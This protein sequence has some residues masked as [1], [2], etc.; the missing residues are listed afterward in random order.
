MSDSVI[1]ISD[2]ELLNSTNNHG[3]SAGKVSSEWV[4]AGKL[5][6]ILY[7]LYDIEQLKNKFKHIYV[8]K[9]NDNNLIVNVKNRK[10]IMF[11]G[12]T[13]ISYASKNIIEVYCNYTRVKFNTRLNIKSTGYF[14][15]INI[16]EVVKY[17]IIWI[18]LIIVGILAFICIFYTL[19]YVLGLLWSEI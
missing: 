13:N 10:Y 4:N 18:T 7:M 17:S 6:P 15:G 8:I 1:G 3:Y 5:N 16:K 19:L 14:E 2:T 9:S 12:E 11:K